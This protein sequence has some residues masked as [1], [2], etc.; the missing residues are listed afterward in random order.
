MTTAEIVRPILYATYGKA[1]MVDALLAE[2][3]RRIDADDWD[4]RGREHGIMLECWNWFSGGSTAASVAAKIEA[5][6]P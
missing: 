2:L 3:V 5:A 1:S 4:R 6:L